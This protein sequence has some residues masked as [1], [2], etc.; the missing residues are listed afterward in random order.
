[1]VVIKQNEQKQLEEGFWDI[2]G[3]TPGSNWSKNRGGTQL[4]AGFSISWPKLKGQAT[5]Y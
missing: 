1:M 5:G 2:R 3:G 4:T